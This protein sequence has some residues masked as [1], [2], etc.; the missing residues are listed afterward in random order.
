MWCSQRARVGDDPQLW[1]GVVDVGVSRKRRSMLATSAV[2][3]FITDGARVLDGTFLV[4]NVAHGSGVEVES[5]RRR[6]M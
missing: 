3:M 6:T 5:R 4:G 1:G 2:V